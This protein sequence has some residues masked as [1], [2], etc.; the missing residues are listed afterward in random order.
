MQVL[1]TC[2]NRDSKVKQ[3]MLVWTCTENG[4]KYSSQKSI[5]YEM[6]RGINLMQQL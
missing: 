5:V 3:V 4:R 1:K 6:M 2:Y